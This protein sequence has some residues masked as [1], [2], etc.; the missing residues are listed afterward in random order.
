VRGDATSDWDIQFQGEPD[1]MQR[2]R[3]NQHMRTAAENLATMAAI[4]NPQ[5]STYSTRLGNG[6][7]RQ[8]EYRRPRQ[9][10]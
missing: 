10:S 8:L 7:Q 4:L 2:Y 3:K 6:M 5:L 1:R 9:R